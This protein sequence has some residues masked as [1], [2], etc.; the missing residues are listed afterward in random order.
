MI[1]LIKLE[2]NSIYLHVVTSVRLATI[3]CS[4]FEWIQFL[5]AFADF[6]IVIYPHQILSKME[7]PFDILGISQSSS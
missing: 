1:K 3:P 2:K 7:L 5:L 6:Q 4:F